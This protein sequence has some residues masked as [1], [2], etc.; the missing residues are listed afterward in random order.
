MSLFG[1][2]YYHYAL[3]LNQTVFVFKSKYI[4]YFCVTV[5]LG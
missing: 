3:L 5:I 1:N 2:K 4:A